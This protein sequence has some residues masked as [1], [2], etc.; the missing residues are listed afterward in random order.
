[1]IKKYIKKLLKGRL[2]FN[3]IQNYAKQEVPFIQA[4]NIVRIFYCFLLFAAVWHI[5][6]TAKILSLNLT[7]NDAELLWPVA[8][9]KLLS[10]PF[11]IKIILLFFIA[12]SLL[13][14]L[15]PW[16]Q[17]TRSLA[18]ISTLTFV[19]LF[20]SFGKIYHFYHLLVLVS[21]LLIF[22]PRKT[23]DR[24]KTLLIILGC[25]AIIF[26]TY[27]LAGVGKLLGIAWRVS[28]GRVSLL[29]TSALARHISHKIVAQNIPS[30]LGDWFIQH[31][32]IG[33]VL[34]LGSVYLLVFSFWAAFK[35]SLH[36]LWAAGLILFHIAIF[37]TMYINFSYNILLLALFFF[38]SPFYEHNWEQ[39]LKDLPIIGYLM[40][41]T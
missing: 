2:L 14:A 38:N 29:D 36:K 17:W 27:T 6:W 37:L 11:A 7:S 12:S 33:W 34:L 4:K 8:W 24:Q 5:E 23:S 21:F 1:M 20:N 30:I 31:Q 16:N 13:A 26:L 3:F 41:K 18:C 15:K 9:A 19:A 39:T 35:P 32:F 10:F 22:L 25:Q 40:P 28:Q